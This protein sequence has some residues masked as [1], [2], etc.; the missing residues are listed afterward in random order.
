MRTCA[1]AKINLFLGV[2]DERDERGYHLVTSLMCPL[3]LSDDVEV[4]PRAGAGV[5]LACE[6][7]PVGEARDNLATRPPCVLARRWGGSPTCPYASP[8]AFPRRRGWAGALPTRRRCC[9]AWRACGRRRH[10]R[11][12]RGRGALPRGRRSFFLYGGACLMLGC[13]DEFSERVEVPA[14]PLAVVRPPAGVSTPAAYRAFDEDK[15]ATPSVGAL[16]GR[17]RERDIPGR[18]PCSRTTCSQRPAACSRSWGRRSRCSRRLT[19]AP[20]ARFSAA[21]VRRARCSWGMT[22]RPRACA[23]WHAHAAGGPVPRAWPRRGRR[24]GRREGAAARR[25]RKSTCSLSLT[26]SPHVLKTRLA[27]FARVG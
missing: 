23:S 25:G 16:M 5:D 11:A 27:F 2:S 14:L 10:R 15:T 17:L 24:C 26:C 22:S 18:L 8:S 3:E 4:K 9:A 20:R 12:R 6:P 1:P 21:V 19:A 13:G 7:D